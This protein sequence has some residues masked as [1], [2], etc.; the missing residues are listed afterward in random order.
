MQVYKSPYKTCTECGRRVLRA[1]GLRA[2]YR[3]YSTQLLMNIPF[4]SLHFM[5]Y[6]H[7]SD[8]INP[9]RSY[10]PT[11]HLV[12]GSAAGAI[13]SLV[14][15]P[16]DVAKTLLNTQVVDACKSQCS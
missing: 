12:A 11:S 15:T 8:I 2:F 16:L 10:S 4:Q 7:A 13:A 9:Q 1:E 6:E 3:S 5:V 14:T